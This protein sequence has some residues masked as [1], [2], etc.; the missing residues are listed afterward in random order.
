M[1][2]LTKCKISGPKTQLWHKL[3]TDIKRVCLL[4]G[5]YKSYKYRHALMILRIRR[6]R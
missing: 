2:K 5:I 4:I 1:H 6:E 3:G